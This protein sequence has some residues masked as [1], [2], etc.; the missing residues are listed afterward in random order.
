M[1]GTLKKEKTLGQELFDS[2]FGRTGFLSVG[3][4]RFA[5]TRS[6]HKNHESSERKNDYWQ[7]ET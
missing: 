7:P 6:C 2:I 3:D 1:E 4:R 5:D